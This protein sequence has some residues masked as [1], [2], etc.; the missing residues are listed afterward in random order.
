MS[1][2]I[3]QKMLKYIQ[4][5]GTA[6]EKAEKTAEAKAANEKKVAEL[7]PGVIEDLVRNGRIEPNQKEAAAKLLSNHAETL[8]LLKKAAQQRNTE[9]LSRL[10]SP[11]DGRMKAASH[12]LSQNSPYVGTRTTTEKE[13]DRI[14]FERLGLR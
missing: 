9:E 4:V 10:G 6:L 11:T 2:T 5:T 12:Q 1:S 13:S 8:K 14:L 3:Q 7:I